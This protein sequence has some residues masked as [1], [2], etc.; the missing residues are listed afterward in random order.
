M[1][2][3]LQSVE[4]LHDL[5][6]RARF[7]NGETRLYDMDAVRRAHPQF[8]SLAEVHGLFQLVRVDPG[9]FGASWN[10]ELD[11][12]CEEI[13]MGGYLESCAS[14]EYDGQSSQS[15]ASSSSHSCCENVDKTD[16]TR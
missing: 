4:P 10:D 14:R 5:I 9:G 3:R 11:I 15:G 7:E 13:Y 16:G 12:S 1:F 8:D 6:I 2:H